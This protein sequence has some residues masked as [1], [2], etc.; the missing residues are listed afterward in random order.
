M[1]TDVKGLLVRMAVLLSGSVLMGTLL[2]ALVFCIPTERIKRHAEGFVRHVLDGEDVFGDHPILR[3]VMGDW[4]SYTDSIMIQYAFEKVPEKNAFEHA[5]WAY[6]YD[7]EEEIWAA[8][9]SLR[10]AL[11]GGDVS[12]MYLREYSRYWHGYL[13]YLKPLLFVMPWECLF[14]LGLGVQLAL[15]AWLAALCVRQKRVGVIA[16][17]A[18]GL[19]FMKPELMVVSLTMSVCFIIT[20]A[21]L[22]VLLSRGE[23]LREEKR[24]P[25]FFLCVGILTAYFDFLTYPVVTLGFP[26]AALFLSEDGE[27]VWTAFRRI[28]GY[29]FCWGVG[30]AGMWAAKWVV[31]DV[32]LHTGTVKDALW[33]V[34]GRTE[35]IGGRPRMNGAAY[36][37]SLNFDEYGS[38]I[39]AVLAA[40]LVIAAV[41]AVAWAF[42]KKLS[43]KTI[44]ESVFPFVIVGAIPFAW[45]VVVQHHSALHA[46]FTFRILGVAAMALG[47]VCVRAVH[48]SHTKKS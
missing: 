22:I 8:E 33:N 39:Y 17:M 45:I 30:Y 31:A 37:I 18:A 13:L 6:H 3:H 29:A 41:L 36:V 9:E 42:R 4:E 24:Y 43:P 23:W 47:C 11:A 38:P 1:K 19:L 46:R 32:T 27:R 25:E 21:A 15:M 26:L 14:W 10:M 2:L 40:A 7:V 12:G 5:M 44:L 48:L 35:T 28:V 34:I 16:A 20:L